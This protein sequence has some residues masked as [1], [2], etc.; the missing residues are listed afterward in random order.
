MKKQQEKIK[1]ANFSKEGKRNLAEAEK[2]EL[3]ENVKHWIS[4][5]VN[6]LVQY[7]KLKE[8][9]YRNQTTY[10]VSQQCQIMF[11]HPYVHFLPDIPFAEVNWHILNSD[12]R[13]NHTQQQTMLKAESARG[14][15]RA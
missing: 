4:Y 7:L 2:S 12:K 6:N 3:S 10:A 9:I 11:P 13:Q 1:P 14:K 5:T 8:N 15:F